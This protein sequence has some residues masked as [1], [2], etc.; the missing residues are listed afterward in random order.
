MNRFYT[1][2]ILIM[3]V[4]CIFSMQAQEIH[5]FC[6]RCHKIHTTSNPAQTQHF[7]DYAGGPSE[8]CLQCH[9]ETL[10]G[11]QLSAPVMSRPSGNELPAG[12]LFLANTPGNEGNGHALTDAPTTYTGNDVANGT[13]PPGGDSGALAQLGCLSCHYPHLNNAYQYRLLRKIIPDVGGGDSRDT[14]GLGG[15]TKAWPATIFDT[16]AG[17]P[18]ETADIW[19]TGVGNN[20]ISPTNTNIYRGDNTDTDNGG[21]GGWCGACHTDYHDDTTNQTG[22][23]A[24]GWERHP[25]NW[26]I[27]TDFASI[28]GGR[29]I[30]DADN[31]DYRLPLDVETNAALT[32][33]NTASA[34]IG[35]DRVFCLTCHKAHATNL[36]NAWR[37]DVNAPQAI[38][39]AWPGTGTCNACHYKD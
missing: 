26:P 12:D 16:T 5:N 18:S 22:A 32:W 9:D 33:D 31:Y 17:T 6:G 36:P 13:T 7:I 27:G 35:A 8:M 15:G 20:A 1:I 29:L 24:T 10:A 23:A 28:E 25:T 21:W 11:D 3:A 30:A 37:W 39:A 4:A 38:K 34:I 2:T 14:T 19:T